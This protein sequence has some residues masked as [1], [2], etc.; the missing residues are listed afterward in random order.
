MHPALPALQLIQCDFQDMR[1]RVLPPIPLNILEFNAEQLPSAM[2]E[3]GVDI[4]ICINMIHISPFECT[5]ALFR[6]ANAIGNEHVRVLTYGPYRVNGFM[7]ESNV[8]FD[9]SLKAR[10]PLWGVRD[11]EAVEAIAGENGFT[12]IETKS[13]PANNLCLIFGRR[14]D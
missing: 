3:R 13:M 14:K 1:D 8:A 7:V 2:R 4:I 5:H 9:A 11:I 12:L 6:T 10:N